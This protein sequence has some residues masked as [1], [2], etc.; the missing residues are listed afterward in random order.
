MV[1]GGRKGA[2]PG[3]AAVTKLTRAARSSVVS[4]REACRLLRG[5]VKAG[6][7]D[8]LLAA[9]TWFLLLAL[10]IFPSVSPLV[11]V[12]V[13]LGWVGLLPSQLW[14]LI[15]FERKSEQVPSGRLGKIN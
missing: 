4:S 13:E 6:C 12:D 10:A 14:A 15:Q 1:F 8:G 3:S 2:V 9:V 11:M 7:R 5:A